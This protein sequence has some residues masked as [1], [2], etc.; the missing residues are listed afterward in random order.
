MDRAR[1]V[2]GVDRSS[3]VEQ[4]GRRQERKASTL[5]GV[6]ASQ[7]G[8]APSASEQQAGT[9][10]YEQ[11]H[12]T[13]QQAKAHYYARQE[14][15]GQYYAEQQG[16]GVQFLKGLAAVQSA[17]QGYHY[18]PKEF[19]SSGKSILEQL[20]EQ[21]EAFKKVL[22]PKK[23]KNLYDATMDMMLIEQ[24][25]KS[26]ALKAIQARLLFK[27]RSVK[28]SGAKSSEIRIAVSKIKKVIGKAKAK[29]KNL[30]NEE[31][32]EKKRKKAEENRRKTKEEALRRELERRKKIR[33]IKEK[34]DVEE[35]K[36]GLG[37]NYGGPSEATPAEIAELA[38]GAIGDQAMASPE[39]GAT[40]DVAV[41]DVGA[42]GDVGAVDVSL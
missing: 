6:N 38:S 3:G 13:Q 4:V 16:Q 35:S 30:Q 39:A 5:R 9:Q 34:N 29:V 10:H 8:E 7:S 12:F 31:Q 17:Q 32:L 40:V 18:K 22:D 26:P 27:I 24:A 11:R 33:K 21:S 28:N 14:D 25:E 23:K 15:K 1:K 41:A 42:V 20:R 36:M 2:S 19:T 37:A